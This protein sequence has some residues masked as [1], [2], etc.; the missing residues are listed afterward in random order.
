MAV[1]VEY[2]PD[3]SSIGN[4]KSE[5]ENSK[6]IIVRNAKLGLTRRA[7][8]SELKWFADRGFMP[9]LSGVEG[10]DAPP[11]GSPPKEG[12]PTGGVGS[13]N[14]KSEIENPK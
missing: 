6:N 2:S 8:K 12:C 7:R 11:S 14:R 5:I 9:A 4:R 13:P 3:G 1:K 10:P